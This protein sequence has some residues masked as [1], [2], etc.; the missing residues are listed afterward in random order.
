M[1][2]YRL[3]ASAIAGRLIEV[4]PVTDDD[5]AAWS[6]GTTIFAAED[7]SDAQSAVVVQA[8][9]LGAGSLAPDVVA[10]LGRRSSVVRRYLAIEGHRALFAANDVLPPVARVLTDPAVAA[11]SDSPVAS[12]ELALGT[13][14]IADAP[15]IFGTIRPRRV[16]AQVE[17]TASG[18][19]AR[20]GVASQALKEYDD[21][22][23]DDALIVDIGSTATGRGGMV[24]RMLK[25]LFG[26]SGGRGAG[27]AG[28]APPT[29]WS[30]RASRANPPFGVTTALASR[31][32]DDGL[33]DHGPRTYPEWDVHRRQYRADWCTVVDVAAPADGPVPALGNVHALRRPLARLGVE[34]DRRHRQ[35]QGDD[36]DIDAAVEAFV[37]LAAGGAP[38]EAIY[39]DSIRCRRDLSVLVLLD[40]SGSAGE[41]GANGTIVH[42]QQQAVAGALLVALHELGDRVALYGFRSSGRSAVQVMPV[43]RFDTPLDNR[44]L[45]RLGALEAAG[46]TRLGAA[47]RHGAAVLEADGGTPRRLLV[48]VSAGFAY[49]H[50]YEGRYGE[51]DARRALAEARR[52]GTACLCLSVGATTEADAL[53]RVFG[54]AAHATIPHQEQ[55]PNVIGP[56]VRAAL[57]TADAQRR[58]WQ[59]R[60]RTRERLRVER[61]A[62]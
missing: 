30:R 36:I 4:A 7:A 17:E 14:L 32:V 50:G 22:R 25:N 54:T 6:D 3:L 34:L 27:N 43:K 10:R 61:R 55:L 57:R 35:L 56:L 15:A 49:D 53:R 18:A 45:R 46:Y 42:E 23:D 8:A 58:V 48:V 31:T 28:G 12:V 39:V 47:I 24:G 40:V 9:L 2:K 60:E 13:E 62:V 44:S 37:A 11:R 33:V 38:E 52:R 29:H 51:A 5:G 20:R 26:D 41:A 1:N 21:D 19:N 59:R 16:R